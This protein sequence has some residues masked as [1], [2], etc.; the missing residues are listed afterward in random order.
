MRPIEVSWIDFTGFIEVPEIAGLEM[1]YFDVRINFFPDWFKEIRMDWEV[2]SEM[3]ALSPQFR[4]LVSESEAGPYRETRPIFSPEPFFVVDTFDSS[5]Y[6]QEFYVL[7]VKLSDGRIL[8]SE[9]QVVGMKLPRWQFLRWKEISRREWIMLDKFYGI[10]CVIFRK[11]EYGARCS[12]CWDAKREV[13]TREHCEHC[14]GTSYEGGYYRGISALVQFNQWAGTKSNT[15]FGKYE[16]NQLMAWT[17]NYPTINPH[18]IILRLTDFT[19]FRVEMTQNTTIMTVPQRQIFKITQLS[20]D[21]IENKLL[22]RREWLPLR[23]RP[24]HIH[25]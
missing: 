7:Q 3:Q 17:L 19:V 1:G 8:K 21:L 14:L 16:P 20:K 12:Y 9:P 10:E 22:Q 25:R 4:V 15:Y 5:K 13:I 18:D 2:P 23:E 24:R 11:R 6:G